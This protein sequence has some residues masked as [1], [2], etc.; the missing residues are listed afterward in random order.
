MSCNHCPV[1]F[2]S[3]RIAQHLERDIKETLTSIINKN[4]SCGFQTS[5]IDEGE[6]SCR[7][8][9]DMV[10]YRYTCNGELMSIYDQLNIDIMIYCRARLTGNSDTLTPPELLAIL[11]EW[12]TDDGTFLYTYHGRMRLGLDQHCPL[13]ITS[14]SQPECNGVTAA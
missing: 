6:F 5:Q 8:L 14:F 3:Q 10:M 13:E 2:S 7:T 9:Q 4:C 12:V 1:Y 11:Q